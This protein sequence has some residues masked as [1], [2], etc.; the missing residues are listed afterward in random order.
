MSEFNNQYIKFMS[1]IIDSGL[2]GR[3]SS[4]AK[5]LYPV[6]LKFSDQNFKQVWPGTD[7]LLKL[8][9]FKTKKSIVLGK[10]ELIKEGLLYYRPGSG[11]TNSVYYFTFNYPGSKIIPQR[12][13]TIPLTGIQTSPRE[14][15]ALTPQTVPSGIPNHLNITITNTQSLKTDKEESYEKLIDMYGIKVVDE[16]YQM[17]KLK[18]FETNLS[19]VAGICKNISRKGKENV[20]KNNQEMDTAQHVIDSWRSFIDWSKM[21][22]TRSSVDILKQISISVDGRSIYIQEDLSDFLKQIIIKYFHE[23][24]DPPILV[25]FSS[26]T[27]R[28]Y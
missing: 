5:T 16:A 9:G 21:H 27:S 28:N 20:F 8:T 6:L 25:V 4:A 26:K 12:D 24:L 15:D 14:D 23:E 19:Y 22:L 11:R 2:W 3:L 1:D 10:K 18:G 13:K 7:L 17:A